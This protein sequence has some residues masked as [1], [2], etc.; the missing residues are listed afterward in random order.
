MLVR[1]QYGTGNEISKDLPTGT[2]LGQALSNESIR[3]GLGYGTNVEGTIGG[4]T[5]PNNVPLQQGMLVV[6]ND[7]ACSKAS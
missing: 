7:K 6:I 1:F 2:T 5:Q 4:V 3:V